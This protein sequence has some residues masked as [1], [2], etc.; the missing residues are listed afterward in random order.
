MPSEHEVRRRLAAESLTASTWGNGP[1]DH[2]PEHRHGYDKVL[3]AAAGAITFH[4]PELGRDVVLAVGDRL[5]LPAGTLHGADVG[6]LGVTCLEAHLPAGT[7]GR[8]PEQLPGWG[9]SARPE[10]GPAAEG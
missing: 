1:F 2:Y 9:A 7:L 3:V 5:D 8:S 6:A 10:A 4:L